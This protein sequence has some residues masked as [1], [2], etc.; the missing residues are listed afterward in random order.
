MFFDQTFYMDERLKN[1]YKVEGNF[2][3]FEFK[4]QSYEYN[5]SYIENYS[6]PNKYSNSIG[7]ITGAQKLTL[8]ANKDSYIPDNI[9]L[10]FGIYS[11]IMA[12]I[13][14]LDPVL[15]ILDKSDASQLNEEHKVV[16][17]KDGDWTGL[18]K[19]KIKIKVDND[20]IILDTTDINDIAEIVFDFGEEND[21]KKGLETKYIIIIVVCCV[22][23]VAVVVVVV[24][25]VLKKKR[26]SVK[27]YSA[28]P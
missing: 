19:L 22:V 25:I 11:P 14:S 10:N 13:D 18:K 16:I 23:V 7:L 28:S 4:K 8:I 24:V 26:T 27:N 9:L 15:Y 1:H 21:K 2:A 3:S 6:L 20:K 12:P 17:T 5:S